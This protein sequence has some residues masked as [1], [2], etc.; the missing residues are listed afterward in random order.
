MEVE[1]IYEMREFIGPSLLAWLPIHNIE[2][3]GLNVL[4]ETME[5]HL[6]AKQDFYLKERLFKNKELHLIFTS[7]VY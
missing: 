2:K 6:S 7:V 5:A 4:Q 1:E 3:E